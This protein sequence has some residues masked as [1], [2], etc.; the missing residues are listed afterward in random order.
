MGTDV[1]LLGY[2]DRNV[3]ELVCHEVA[4]RAGCYQRRGIEVEAVPGAAYPEASLSA[5]L[6]GSLVEALRGQR[7]WQ[8]VL[9]HTVHPLFWIWARADSPALLD[10]AR[11]AGHPD[12]SIVWAFTE[13]LLRD[14]GVRTQDLTREH[15]P[16]GVQG[17]HQRLEALTSGSVDAAVIGSTFAPSALSRLGLTQRLFFGDG[18]KFPTVGVAVDIDRTSLDDPIVRSVVEAQRDA[19]TRI[20]AKDRIAVEA[21]RSL[22]PGSV[23]EDAELLLR[24]YVSLQYGL[25]RQEVQDVGADALAWLSQT[26][27]TTPRPVSNFYEEIA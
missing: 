7:R 4:V 10:I 3:H 16:V 6:G 20:K 12:G 14:L 11:L 15:F 25:E 9:A 27:S 24:D 21:V 17:D 13:Q 26:L 1:V 5:G 19:L 18:I 8:G 23:R 2:R 22:L